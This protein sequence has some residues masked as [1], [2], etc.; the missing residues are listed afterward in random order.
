[1]NYKRILL[2]VL[3]LALLATVSICSIEANNTADS[4]RMQMKHLTGEHLLQAH[5]NLCRLAAGQDNADEELAALNAYMDEARRQNDVESE[6]QA[7]TMQIMCYYNYDMDDRLKE[8]LPLHLAFMREHGLWDNY[9]NSW[10]TLVELHIYND[11]LQT[12]LIEADKMY[13]DAKENKSNHGIGVSGYC[14][15]SIY[16][17]MQRFT[18]AK[19]SLEE[20]IVA[21][22]KEEDISLLLAAYN[23]L[24][25]T[26]DGLGQYE[27]LRS[28][29]SKWKSVLDNYKQMA[30]AKGYTPSLNGQYL[31]CTL[32]ALVAEIETEQ[33]DRAAELLLEAEALV[34]GRNMI[35][36]YKFLQVQA[37]YYAAIKLY[38]K[39][40]ASNNENMD[41]LL[42][43][44]DSVSLL[45]VELQQAHLLHTAG[46]HKEAAELYKQIIPRK[47]KL[48]NHELTAQLDELRTLYEVDKLTLKNQIATNR[49]YF[50]LVSS[51]LLLIMVFSYIIYTRS[52]RR[53]NRILFDIYMQSKRK[54]E[55]L[56]A[57]KEKAEKERLSNEEFL[58]NKLNKLMQREHLYKDQKMRK[59]DVVAKL[60]TNRT[61]LA[62]A[63][64][65]CANGM[66]FSE[67]INLYRLRYAAT[68]LTSNL[69][70]NIYQVGDESGFNSRSTYNRLFQDY[71]GMS[72]SEFRDIAKEKQ[73]R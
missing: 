57:I 62:D 45:T 7:R 60:N 47:D 2:S 32:A 31:N 6:G 5:S 69:D 51:I 26:L 63:I 15:G 16:Q 1:M 46:Q 55:K 40:I 68:L 52:L 22:S 35:W 17:A 8:T 56:S 29:T 59:D 10:N 3:V 44:G 65:E 41:I 66:T 34:D 67:Y 64:K 54:E 24:G 4:I 19:Q 27:E 9:Y 37:R 71:Y 42:S 48:R 21:L 11:E 49:L 61:Y 36:R 33:H 20:S 72:P 23:A 30:E 50:L 12:A 14:M 28:M 43:V 53:K 38:D 13:A 39:A 18:L 73:I 25:E 58:Y 70:M